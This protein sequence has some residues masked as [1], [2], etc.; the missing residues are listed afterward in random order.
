M[1]NCC[2]LWPWISARR[3][4][5][6]L[7]LSPPSP[8]ESPRLLQFLDHFKH[9]WAGEGPPSHGHGAKSKIRSVLVRISLAIGG[10]VLI[11]A[12]SVV[13]QK[14]TRRGA[15][16]PG[17]A[18]FLVT[19]QVGINEPFRRHSEPLGEPV[20]LFFAE[21]RL[22]FA[23]AIRAG[24][25]I[26]AGPNT[27][28]CFRYLSIHLVG[29][30]LA[31]KFNELA[32]SPALVLFLL[33]KSADLHE[34]DGHTSS[35]KC[36]AS[37]CKPNFRRVFLTHEMVVS[38][39]NRYSEGIMGWGFY[40][41]YVPVAR[42]R[43]NALREVRRFAAKGKQISP[44]EIAGRVIAS[45]FWGKA[46]CDNLESYSD[47]SNRLPRGRTYV[48]NGSVVDLQIEPGKITSM[49][50][51][52]S[53]YRIAISIG[54]L[55]APRWKRLKLQC[56]AGIGSVVEL[57]QGRLSSSVMAV[58][59]S[60]EN[61]LF[62]APAE[63]KMACSC[64]DWAGMCKHVAATLYGVGNRLDRQPELFFKLRQVD[65]LE[66]IAEAGRE[67][68]KRKGTGGKTIATDQLANVFGIELETEGVTTAAPERSQAKPLRRKKSA[69][70][71]KEKAARMD[72]ASAPKEAPAVSSK[73]AGSRC[74]TLT[75][76]ERKRI[77]EAQRKRWQALN[78][79]GL[80]RN[81]NGA[82]ASFA[83]AAKISKSHPVK[84]A[85]SKPARRA[86]AV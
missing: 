26:D 58:V 68:P 32:E 63:I 10:A 36:F 14:R 77:A 25:A 47:F 20:H 61:G 81:G 29:I 83:P 66:L 18:L 78:H 40:A 19:F 31:L 24:R 30:E 4:K 54:P 45:T 80:S 41:P 39:M 65:H 62:P 1:P 11:N 8:L 28:G 37:G 57:L 42:R 12:A 35:M 64:P 72:A 52:S 9:D 67:A 7:A 38:F 60:R 82:E 50:S 13:L 23:A 16:L 34:I 15:R 75:A 17:I 2:A 51:G 85:R 70:P 5:N 43:A 53:L 86:P 46:W 6:R 27:L 79:N 76:A 48:R 84:P 56:G 55:A 49:V 33:G 3:W 74:K 69:A 22:D 21:R 59:T 73:S 71:E 44:V